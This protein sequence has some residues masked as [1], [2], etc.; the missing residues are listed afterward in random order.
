MKLKT[1]RYV[2]AP[3]LFLSPVAVLAAPTTLV[4]T[5]NGANEPGGGDAD[6]SGQFSA[7]IDP[8]TGEQS[9]F[10]ENGIIPTPYGMALGPDGNIY[11][12]DPY[13]NYTPAGPASGAI[14]KVDRATGAQ[15]SH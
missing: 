12:A 1:S 11:V 15:S 8:D 13:Y 14:I 4:S 2:L 6:G 9:V 10:S 3:I 7:E 5:L